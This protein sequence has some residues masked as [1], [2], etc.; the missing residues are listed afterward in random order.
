MVRI[1]CVVGYPGAGKSVATDVAEE[2]GIATTA[3]GD[4]V[5]ERAEREL[6]GAL[7]ADTQQEALASLSDD[8]RAELE[9]EGEDLD[10][11]RSSL[12]G[13][14]ATVQRERHGDE[15]VAEWTA[16]YIREH[17][18]SDTVLVDGV[19]SCEERDVFQTEFETVEVVHVDAPFQTRLRRLQERG[20]DGEDEFTSEDLVQRDDREDSWGVGEIVEEADITVKNTRTLEEYKTELRRILST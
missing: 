17:V 2:C 14:W 7:S 15:V 18:E 9:S 19:R 16:Q 12:I 10:L 3:M 8:V 5:R 20:R 13:T 11:S 4:Q 6:Q 1:I